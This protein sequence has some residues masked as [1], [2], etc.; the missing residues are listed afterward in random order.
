MTIIEEMHI[1][2]NRTM[3]LFDILEAIYECI[4]EWR[5]VSFFRPDGEHI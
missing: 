3:A 4:A 1:L 2:H 5:P